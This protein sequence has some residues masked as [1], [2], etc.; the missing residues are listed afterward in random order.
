LLA[1]PVT[2]G[3]NTT[4]TKETRTATAE[5]T[6]NI[7]AKNVSINS[8]NDTT[9]NGVERELAEYGDQCGW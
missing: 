3:G 4:K 2:F 7:N 8:T 1:A 5:N 9:L 6:T